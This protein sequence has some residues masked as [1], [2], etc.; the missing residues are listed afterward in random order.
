VVRIE[1]TD[2][3]RETLGKAYSPS[4]A[5]SMSHTWQGYG[6]FGIAA[7]IDVHDVAAT[8]AAIRKALTD[9]RAAPVDADVLQR[10]RQPLIE[11]LQNALKSNEG[12]AALVS[13]AQ[14][15]PDQIER[16]TKART[17]LQTIDAKDLQAMALRYLDPAVGLEVLVLPDGVEPPPA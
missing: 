3:L 4:A 9:L 10:A 12:W 13:R 2:T 8:R 5:S 15:D 17:R 11:G 6:T 16:Y 14:G 1:L 7:S